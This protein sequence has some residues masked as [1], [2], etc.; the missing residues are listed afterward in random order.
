[1]ILNDPILAA[2]FE[3]ALPYADFVATGEA[4][5]H[6]PPWDQRYGQLALDPEQERLVQSF[7]RPMNVLCMTGTW[8]GD[9]ALQGSAMARVAEA[10]PPV[11]TLRYVVRSERHAE[12][13]TKAQLNAGFRVPVT[14]FMAEDMEPVGVIGDRT[15]SRY[16]AIARKQL[17]PAAT[18]VAEPPADPVREVLREILGEFERV[19]LL[20][21]L[22]PR[23]RQKHGD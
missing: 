2:T 10:N 9:C 4:E 6:R 20:L 14:W 11:I 18:V 5:G 13:V 12:P 22:S 8:C 7:T 23:L 17:G 15:L 16:R 19:Q 3:R 1:M 21:R